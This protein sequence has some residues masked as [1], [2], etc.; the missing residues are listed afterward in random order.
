VEPVVDVLSLAGSR[1]SRS[2]A[3]AGKV[4][5]HAQTAGLRAETLCVRELPAIGLVSGDTT[6]PGVAG[7]LESVRQARALVVATPIYQASYTGLLKLL[8]DLLPVDSLAGKVV[9][10]I[11]V[12]AV[13]LHALALEHSLAP[14]LASRSPRLI[15]PGLF[16]PDEEADA[17]AHIAAAARE[18]IVSLDEV[19]TRPICASHAASDVGSR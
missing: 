5:A 19:R 1:S 10:P 17:A 15:L 11:A 3:L 14:L 16:V 8:L 18:L 6:R 12:G 9:L 13:E 4:L 7:A 2:H